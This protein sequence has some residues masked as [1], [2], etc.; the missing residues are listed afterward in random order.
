MKAQE[1]HPEPTTSLLTHAP[2]HMR[3]MSL[4]SSANLVAGRSIL[5]QGDYVSRDSNATG[6]NLVSNVTFVYLLYGKVKFDSSDCKI[7]ACRIAVARYVITLP[8][9]THNGRWGLKVLEWPPRTR[10]RSVGRPPTRWTD[11]I[12]RAAGGK[13]P[14]IVEL[15]T[16]DLCPAM[17][18]DWLT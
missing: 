5:P 14:R 4:H 1:E 9:G 3:G 6:E 11:D 18:V 10:K 15:P 12:R 7:Y 13:R 2:W 17:G 8:E 16:K